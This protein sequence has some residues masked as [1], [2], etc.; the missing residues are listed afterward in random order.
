MKRKVLKKIYD[1][2]IF[3]ETFFRCLFTGLRFDHTWSVLGRIYVVRPYFFQAPAILKIGRRFSANSKITNNTYGIFQNVLL[4]VAPGGELIIGDNVGISG[5]TVSA[6]KSIRIGNN[7]LIGSGC[8]ICDS[9]AHPIHPAD[10]PFHERTKT[11]PIRIENDV[12]IGARTL[13]LKG[14]TIGRGSMIGAGSV[15]VKSIPPMSVAAG[16]PAKIIKEM[17]MESK[18]ELSK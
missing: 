5:S 2:R 12:F 18:T 17:S 7:V 4:R 15:V 16:N 13:V 3:T 14:V 10:R 11:A 6:V 1:I 8:I 9:D